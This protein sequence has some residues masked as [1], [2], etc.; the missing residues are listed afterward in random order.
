MDTWRSEGSKLILLVLALV[1]AFAQVRF[2]FD[3][4]IPAHNR[5]FIARF[6]IDDVFFRMV[7]LPSHAQVYIVTTDIVRE[8]DIAA[9]LRYRGRQN[10]LTVT[11]IRPEALETGTLAGSHHAC[12]HRH[13]R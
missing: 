7:T 13:L 8:Y 5:Q 1:I 12:C 4:Q 9:Y 2:Y 10:D 3:E 6:A 11:A